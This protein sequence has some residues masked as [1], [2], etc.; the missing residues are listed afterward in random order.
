MK[1]LY[2]LP[3]LVLM[4]GCGGMNLHKPIIPGCHW[5]GGELYDSNGSEVASVIIIPFHMDTAQVCIFTGPP[6]I[7]GCTDWEEGQQAYDYVGR[8]LGASK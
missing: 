2:L 4:A 6:A 3:L 7:T 1:S 5:R 8:E